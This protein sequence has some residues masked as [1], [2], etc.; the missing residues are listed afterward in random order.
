MNPNDEIAATDMTTLAQ[1]LVEVLE[2]L[3]GEKL[4]QATVAAIGEHRRLTIIAEDAYMAWRRCPDN[5]P[6]RLS[7]RESYNRASL[8]NRA[9]IAIVA[10]LTDK[11][12]YIPE[13][14]E[15]QSGAAC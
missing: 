5:D 1:S 2:P 13:V 6:Q 12:G 4:K 11:L 9:Q 14:G 15:D 10:A 7:L 3:S 8:Q